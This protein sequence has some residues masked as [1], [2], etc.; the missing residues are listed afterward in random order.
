M[1]TAGTC[2]VHVSRLAI[3]ATRHAPSLWTSFP[4]G[5]DPVPRCRGKV[6]YQPKERQ[7]KKVNPRK[8]R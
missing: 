7:T 4:V 6:Y 8:L 3:M 5:F 2:Q 1:I